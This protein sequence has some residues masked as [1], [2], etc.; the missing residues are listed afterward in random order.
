MNSE[1]EGIP[2]QTLDKWKEIGPLNLEELA[3]NGKINFDATKGIT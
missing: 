2:G 1:P 3:R